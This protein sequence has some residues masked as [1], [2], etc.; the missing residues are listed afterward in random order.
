MTVTAL[1][2]VSGVPHMR[3]H[4]G[5]LTGFMVCLDSTG[6]MAGK[7]SKGSRELVCIH[8][9]CQEATLNL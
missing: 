3:E 7:E 9:G 8:A 6:K 1:P 4:E 5:T 2:L